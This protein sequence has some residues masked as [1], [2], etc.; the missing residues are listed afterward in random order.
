MTIHPAISQFGPANRSNAGSAEQVGAVPGTGADSTANDSLR[1]WADASAWRR[2]G[3]VRSPGLREMQIHRESVVLRRMA[4]IAPCAI[5]VVALTAGVADDARCQPGTP[6]PRAL[7]APPPP[8]DGRYDFHIL[9]GRWQISDEQLLH[10]L[11]G[12]GVPVGHYGTSEFRALRD[13]QGSVETVDATRPDSTPVREVTIMRY[14][15]LARQWTIRRGDSV[16]RALGPAMTGE[17]RD[18]VGTFLG[19]QVHRGRLVLVRLRWTID[20]PNTALFEREFSA[21]G[22]WTWELNRVTTYYRTDNPAGGIDSTPPDTVFTLRSKRALPIVPRI[23]HCCDVLDVLRYSVPPSAHETLIALFDRAIDTGEDSRAPNE[24]AL[25]RDIDR[26]N[27]FVWLR[28]G[29]GSTD[30]SQLD[31]YYRGPDWSALRAIADRAGIRVDSVHLL[32]PA[33]HSHL[34]LGERPTRSATGGGIVVVTRY[35][36]HRYA[37]LRVGPPNI[38][39][40]FRRRMVPRLFAAGARPIATFT[41]HHQAGETPLPGLPVREPRVEL[42]W[43]ARYP[44]VTAYER[45]VATLE[46]DPV[47]ADLQGILNEFLAAPVQVWRLVPVGRSAPFR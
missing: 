13:G 33:L 12:G 37:V 2:G 32:R 39:D 47:W 21:D 19:Q 23:V 7:P 18:G 35:T 8:R 26:A 24:V 16:G 34:V 1:R 17:F 40:F 46:R 31:A 44:D 22:G 38:E 36:F 29:M 30:A 11:T 6:H 43:F 5:L 27:A 20:G 14:D 10:P 4:R 9:H 3:V 25:F 42:I 28:G 45:A 41:T 15:S